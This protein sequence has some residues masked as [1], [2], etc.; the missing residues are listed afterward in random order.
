MTKR[1]HKNN[2]HITKPLLP[3]LGDLIPY[4]EKIWDSG[5]ITNSGFMTEEFESE[6]CIYLGEKHLSLVSN[7][8][9]ALALAI[10]VLQ[11][12]GEIIT[13]AFTHISTAQSIYWNHLKPV[14]VDV[15]TSDFNI[16]INKIEEAITEETTAI[17][18]V[19]V[20]GNPCDIEGIERIARKHQLKV[21]YDAA[22]GFGV[23]YKGKSLCHYGDISILSFHATK[24]FNSIEG[25]AVICRDIATKKRVDALK[26]HGF[27]DEDRLVGYGLNAKMNELQAAYG[28]LQLKGI[29]QAIENRKNAVMKYR[30]LLKDISG[31]SFLEEQKD[32]KSNY[33][34][35]PILIEPKVFGKS[36]DE[37]YQFYKKDSIF[38]KRYF[39]PLVIDYKEFSIFKTRELPLAQRVAENILCLPLSHSIQSSD[40]E[41]IVGLLKE[42]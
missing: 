8:S 20:F 37:V 18:A 21:I 7:G 23:E 22:H 32:T 25:G 12:K 17:L 35:F 38:T 40:I 16:D 36:R 33:S 6:L 34:Y 15:N 13:T 31:V 27:D 24:V 2:I 26:N 3:P 28:L 9:M 42:V 10:Q 41:R 39:Y 29:T 1:S 30:A 19:H 4:L 5:F 14:F 11:L